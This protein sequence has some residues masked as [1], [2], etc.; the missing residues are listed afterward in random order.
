MNYYFSPIRSNEKIRSIN[1]FINLDDF[2]HK[3]HRPLI[4]REFQTTG[5]DVSKQMVSNIINLLAHYRNWAIKENLYPELYLIYTES[6]D[7]DNNVRLTT[8]RDYYRKINKEENQNYFYVN[9][10]IKNSFDILKVICKYI[11]N[12]NL[13]NSNQI[14]P[15]IIPYYISEYYPKDYNLLITRDEY[16]LQYSCYSKWALM[17]P[18]GDKTKMV[19]KKSLWEYVQYY[20]G[21][22]VDT[23][24]YINPRL[25]E[26]C[27]ALL[28]D[29]YRSIPKLGRLSWNGILKR[30]KNTDINEYNDDS[31]DIYLKDFTSKVLDKKI[32]PDNYYNNLYCTSVFQQVNSILTIKKSIIDH[33]I[34]SFDDP[35]ALLELNNTIFRKYPL[36]IPFLTKEVNF[37]NYI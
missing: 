36:L 32:N 30:L 21:H 23:I 25:F 5:I 10:A 26:Y 27:K 33:Q 9:L 12:C 19:T 8:Y 28:G 13:I 4:D 15:S 17:V 24:D 37:N 11:K 35:K 29:K 31:I 20:M 3:L 22:N 16:D 1:I 18:R 14:E 6:M 7:F 34:I 2:F